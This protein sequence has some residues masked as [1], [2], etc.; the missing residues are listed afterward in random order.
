MQQLTIV[1]YDYDPL[2]N[3]INVIKYYLMNNIDNDGSK[4]KIMLITLNTISFM[5][6]INKPVVAIN[7][8]GVEE[9]EG[10][11]R[12]RNANGPLLATRD[13]PMDT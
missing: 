3:N 1:N 10:S 13:P 4:Y 8:N 11:R 12:R 2:Q 5:N 7:A 6:N 9:V